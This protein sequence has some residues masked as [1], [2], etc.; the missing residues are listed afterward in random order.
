M[1]WWLEGAPLTLLEYL[2]TEEEG[3]TQSR[4]HRHGEREADSGEFLLVCAC[5]VVVGE[6]QRDPPGF[7]VGWEDGW[8]AVGAQEEAEKH[9]DMH[10]LGPGRPPGSVQGRQQGSRHS[11]V[12]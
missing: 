3:L 2:E 10:I 6:M 1:S 9:G 4:A 5:L 8:R 7:E 12:S 11:S